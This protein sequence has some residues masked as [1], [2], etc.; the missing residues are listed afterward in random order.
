MREAR[1]DPFVLRVALAVGNVD[2]PMHL[3]AVRIFVDAHSSCWQPPRADEP[4]A[5]P[6]VEL[7]DPELVD[8]GKEADM[9]HGG[10]LESEDVRA[11]TR[12][13]GAG[14]DAR[15]ARMIDVYN[16]ALAFVG[17]YRR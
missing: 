16:N 6:L 11:A 9:V 4:Q 7:R 1:E 12:W 5:V 14:E 2:K 8:A 15:T 3:R 10:H 17:V 13:T